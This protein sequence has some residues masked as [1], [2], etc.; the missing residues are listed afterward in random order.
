MSQPGFKV[1]ESEAPPPSAR[2][3]TDLS[4]TL[5]RF[6]I[7]DDGT[8][9][10]QAPKKKNKRAAEYSVDLD[11]VK[12]RSSPDQLSTQ[13]VKEFAEAVKGLSAGK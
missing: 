12:V 5:K 10:K 7:S 1:P 3:A 4:F 8:V 2:S 11:G 13:E 9:P 6:K